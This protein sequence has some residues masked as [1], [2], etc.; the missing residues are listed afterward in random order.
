MRFIN[1]LQYRL[2]K[3]VIVPFVLAGVLFICKDFVGMNFLSADPLVG[4]S[5]EADGPADN[6]KFLFAVFFITWLAFFAYIF[7]L[8][9]RLSGM[10]REVEELRKSMAV[11]SQE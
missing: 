9:K 3:F 5:S 4:S 1:M 11:S 2:N 8:S 10:K 7:F 6:L